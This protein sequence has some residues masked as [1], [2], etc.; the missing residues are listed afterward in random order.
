MHPQAPS[1]LSRSDLRYLNLIGWLVVAALFAV[2]LQRAG[3]AD[4]ERDFAY[5]YA[6]GYLLNH[7]PVGS[8]YDYQLQSHLC[9]E[10]QPLHDGVYGPYP[11]P[12]FVAALSS[13]FARLPYLAAYGLWLAIT[14]TLYT[15]GILLLAF[16]FFPRDR[17]K[18]SLMLCFALLFWPFAA[19]TFLNGQIAAIGFFAMAL[20][21]FYEDTS[22]AFSSG[23][24]LSICL[25]KPTLLIL[26]L[27]ILLIIRRYRTLAGFATGAAGLVSLTTILLGPGVWPAYCRMLSQL[28]VFR[29]HLHLD[30]HVDLYSFSLLISHGALSVQILFLCIAV[31]AM[32]YLVR[33]AWLQRVPTQSGPATLLWSATLSWTLLLN[34][35]V[36]IQDSILIF[37]SLIAAGPALLRFHR[38]AFLLICVALLLVS[39]F[40]A[41]IATN[42]SLQFLS[43]LLGTLAF[44]QTR[45]LTGG[46][47]TCQNFPEPQIWQT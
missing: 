13:P 25:Y 18:Q 12:P 10:F 47:L 9:A 27:P 1:S 44:L 30:D 31:A 19:R 15:A 5:F 4:Q 8:L 42:T 23:L 38:G 17:L 43:G 36:P 3:R 37:V 35:Y 32:A 33:A 11:Y 34:L 7:H 26:I 29:P 39:P 21:V 41:F 16:R 14:L 28:A 22:A 45:L 6:F 24:A 20:A 46:A 40:T 2:M